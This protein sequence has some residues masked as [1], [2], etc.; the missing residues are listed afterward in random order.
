MLT[1]LEKHYHD[2]AI[3]IA[4]QEASRL[5][6]LEPV[7][8]PSLDLV[9]AQPWH[10]KYAPWLIGGGIATLG[11]YLKKKKMASN[12]WASM[13]KKY[14]GDMPEVGPNFATSDDE[15]SS[16]CSKLIN[17]IEKL[18]LPK[19]KEIDKNIILFKIWK[20][21]GMPFN[22][23]SDCSDEFYKAICIILVN[24]KEPP[25]QIM[26]FL[27]RALQGDVSAKKFVVDIIRNYLLVLYDNESLLFFEDLL[28]NLPKKRRWRVLF[29]ASRYVLHYIDPSK[30]DAFKDIEIKYPK[31]K[32]ARLKEVLNLPYKPFLFT[33]YSE[34]LVGDRIIALDI[35]DLFKELHHFE[36]FVGSKI[37][38]FRRPV[39][40]FAGALDDKDVKTLLELDVSLYKKIISYAAKTYNLPIEKASKDLNINKAATSLIACFGPRWKYWLEGMEARGANFHDAT[41]WLP[42]LPLD[43]KKGKEIGDFLIKKLFLK[44]DGNPTLCKP[45]GKTPDG[46]NHYGV[47]KERNIKPVY[48]TECSVDN[49]ISK[50]GA[51]VNNWDTIND[52]LKRKPFY[53]IFHIISSRK[54]DCVFDGLFAAAASAVGVS[55]KDY[56]KYESLWRTRPKKDRLPDI[57]LTIN[58]Y[59]FYK[60]SKDDPKALFAGH[61]TGCCQHPDAQGAACAWYGV[62]SKNSAIYAIKDKNHTMIAISWAWI[63]HDLFVF[64]S[65]ET[66]WRS[67]MPQSPISKDIQDVQKVIVTLFEKAADEIIKTGEF[68][69]V[70]VGELNHIVIKTGW[71]KGDSK[72]GAMLPMDYMKFS[73]ELNLPC[74]SDAVKIDDSK[75]AKFNQR[76]IK[77][78]GNSQWLVASV[79]ELAKK[80]ATK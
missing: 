35:Q 48:L 54:Y 49:Q 58:G 30:E 39:N 42:D 34:H 1:P 37:I 40:P 13:Q 4:R 31:T 5:T 56:P 47:I 10:V 50:A 8:N 43:S 61:Y 80:E 19:K 68:S 6:A 36:P 18:S 75:R 22:M 24:K 38:P 26:P 67:R 25:L 69:S 9:A 53:Y 78:I 45:L 62:L 65:I 46:R 57:D 73:R 21:I 51:I 52:D 32:A 2:E 74:Y 79:E 59:H 70:R 17:E 55:P 23:I 28:K 72:K 76:I 15:F 44:Y 3:R 66:K 71:K 11:L 16:S 20:I 27:D 7:N 33:I 41:F 63:N 12:P 14:S 60:M 77:E 29:V 64:D